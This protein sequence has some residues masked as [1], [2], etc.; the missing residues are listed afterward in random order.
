MILLSRCANST[1]HKRCPL[2]GSEPELG[3]YMPGLL[4][5]GN[6]G[7]QCQRGTGIA[8]RRKNRV[9]VFDAHSVPTHRVVKSR[10][11]PHLEIDF[12][13]DNGHSA[14]NLIRLLP[15]CPDWHVVS[16]LG[17]TLLRKKSREQ[18][19]GV[20]Q[21]H[22]PYPLFSELWLNLKTAASLIIE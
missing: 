9:L 11:A 21:I 22:L 4:L 7:V 3:G 19:V 5:Q 16:Q 8:R 18:N 12:A 6:A 2:A 13:S 15:V 1:K 17:H 20:R 10:L 14:N